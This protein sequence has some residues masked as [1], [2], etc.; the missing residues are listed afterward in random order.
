[1]Q[2]S[3]EQPTASSQSIW[4]CWICMKAVSV[5]HIVKIEDGGG[6]TGYCE[7]PHG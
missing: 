2:E 5:A 1:M 6:R 3:S 7:A 4:W